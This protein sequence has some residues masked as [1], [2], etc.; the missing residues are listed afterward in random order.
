MNKEFSVSLSKFQLFTTIS[1]I[2]L[3]LLIGNVIIIQQEEK[4]PGYIYNAIV[5]TIIISCYLVSLS[6][7]KVDQNNIYL[8]TKIKTFTIPINEIESV[9][10]KSQQNIFPIFGWRWIFGL[11]GYT[12]DGYYCNI[13]DTKKLIGIQLANKKY[14]ISC[15]QPEEF[16][17]LI[18]TIKND[19]K[20][21]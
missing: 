17:H 2:T 18:N 15:D 14:L 13:K 20:I 19:K 1:L 5:I 12:M 11:I 3:L 4:Y 10:K 8:V 16:I 9:S 6:V 7:I 21:T